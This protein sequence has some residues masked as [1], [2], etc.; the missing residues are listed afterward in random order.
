MR[1]M[2]LTKESQYIT[3]HAM[4]DTFD[5]HGLC[6]PSLSLHMILKVNYKYI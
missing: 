6:F 4:F 3:Y 1:T 2:T 5:H